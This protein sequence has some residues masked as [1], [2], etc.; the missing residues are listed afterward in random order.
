MGTFH[1]TLMLHGAEE[2]VKPNNTAQPPTTASLQA[3]TKRGK[4]ELGVTL[5]F[6]TAFVQGTPSNQQPCAE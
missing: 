6:H 5:A 2:H 3:Q 1:L 4:A